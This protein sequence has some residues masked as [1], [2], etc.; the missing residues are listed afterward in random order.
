MD[1]NVDYFRELGAQVRALLPECIELR[2]TLHMHPELSLSETETV[3]TLT[4]FLKRHGLSP[5]SAD[6]PSII[7][8]TGPEPVIALRADMDALPVK[9]NSGEVFSSRNEG[10]MHACGHDAHS[11]ILAG[12]GVLIR[13]RGRTRARLI[14]Q[15]AEEI[16]KGASMM[17]GS[18]VLNGIKLIF[19][20]HV[21]PSLDTGTVAILDGPAMAAFDEFSIKISGGGGHGAYP[22]LA[23]D[24]ILAASSIVTSA[25]WLVSRIIDPVQSA[26]LSFGSIQ[27]GKAANVIP[28]DVTMSGTIRTFSGEVRD[29]LMDGLRRVCDRTAG[30]F[31]V[32][33]TIDWR[34]SSPPVV[35]DASFASGCRTIASSFIKNVECSKTMGSEDFAFYLQKVRGAFAFL[36]TGKDEGTRAS[37]HSSAFRLDEEAIYYGIMLET[38]IAEGVMK[39]D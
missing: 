28:S 4:A 14:F 25:N 31:G 34:S 27:G 12:A 18:N 37:K 1:D 29:R 2:R 7:C 11:A 21:W 10:V 19:G 17:I 8:D 30:L 9:E 15:P 23:K 36:G 13:K 22:H 38:A 35:N 5:V 20:L 24:S 16:G 6:F 33:V 3:A 32:N 26:V 39:Q